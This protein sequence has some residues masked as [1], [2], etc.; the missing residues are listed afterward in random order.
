MLRATEQ[1]TW[2]APL[3]KFKRG[4][5]TIDPSSGRKGSA[6]DNVDWQYVSGKHLR[7]KVLSTQASDKG[8]SSLDASSQTDRL[9]LSQEATND[10]QL[11]VIVECGPFEDK[12][13]AT[14][15]SAI[16]LK[17]PSFSQ[18]ASPLVLSDVD[19]VRV[20]RV[21]FH[22]EYR[23]KAVI[24]YRQNK[25]VLLRMLDERDVNKAVRLQLEFQKDEDVE[26][27]LSLIEVGHSAVAIFVM[28]SH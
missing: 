7:C 3:D 16:D 26:T 28:T 2:L 20:N 24:V 18:T 21:Y 17:L 4:Y 15:K 6:G 12:R 14:S 9:L 25:C 19:V 23:L 22:T 11:R 13:L 8:Q 27:F 10:R 5:E 1:L